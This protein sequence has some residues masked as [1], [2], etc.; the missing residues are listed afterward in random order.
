M[1]LATMGNSLDSCKLFSKINVN[2]SYKNATD[3][4][5][6]N[7]IAQRNKFLELVTQNVDTTDGNIQICLND[8]INNLKV[9]KTPQSSH[10]IFKSSIVKMLYNSGQMTD[11]CKEWERIDT[12]KLASGL[13]EIGM[14]PVLLDLKRNIFMEAGKNCNRWIVI[15]YVQILEE[16]KISFT[17]T[18]IY[19][20]KVLNMQ[21]NIYKTLGGRTSNTE[22][23]ILSVSEQLKTYSEEG[24]PAV[25]WDELPGT[26]S[27]ICNKVWPALANLQ[28]VS[29][30]VLC[31]CPSSASYELFDAVINIPKLMS[32]V[33]PTIERECADVSQGYYILDQEINSTLCMV[34][35]TLIEMIIQKSN[36]NDEDGENISITMS[37]I[38]KKR[39]RIRNIWNAVKNV[40]NEDKIDIHDKYSAQQCIQALVNI[41]NITIKTKIVYSQRIDIK[42][43]IHQIV[44]QIYIHVPAAV[45][46]LVCALND[47]MGTIHEH[48]GSVN[49]NGDL[50]T[51]V[52]KRIHF[53]PMSF[54]H[55]AGMIMY[56]QPAY[57]DVFDQGDKLV[58]AAVLA[59]IVTANKLAVQWYR[60]EI[61]GTKF[62]KSSRHP[63]KSIIQQELTIWYVTD[64]SWISICW[65]YQSDNTTTV[66]DG[67][68]RWTGTWTSRTP[69]GALNRTFEI[70][71]YTRSELSKW[72]TKVQKNVGSKIVCIAKLIL[73]YDYHKKENAC[74]YMSK[75]VYV[76][77]TT[78][79]LTIMPTGAQYSLARDMF[80]VVMSESNRGT[81][82]PIALIEWQLSK[83]PDANLDVFDK[84]TGGKEHVTQQESIT[85]NSMLY[86][87]VMIGPN[88]IWE[89]NNDQ[90]FLII[91]RGASWGTLRAVE[92]LKHKLMYEK[93]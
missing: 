17:G 4:M 81:L 76:W 35:M 67:S 86:E 83:V 22:Q 5:W 9:W 28:Y 84:C 10:D 48:R 19:Q 73:I 26:I 34:I 32:R 70:L 15:S 77:S 3:T 11:I 46:K 75:I 7:L 18:G 58:A 39:P 55:I 30:P 68:T 72:Y 74:Q 8:D 40:A 16:E 71:G 80:G 29:Q 62:R 64:N 38:N 12:T 54:K 21:K 2:L 93:N 45:E 66:S 14:G 6:Q 78:N 52:T 92:K 88:N 51:F 50:T 63:L 1:K 41:T 43:Q 57:G 82:C 69:I 27:I 47:V 85:K 31:I 44:S 24:C 91:D 37:N 87:L 33:W 61:S 60:N 65:E 90:S 53:E 36:Q 20:G 25:W 79:A 13:R 23:E 56:G 59:N 49:E 42:K 89:N